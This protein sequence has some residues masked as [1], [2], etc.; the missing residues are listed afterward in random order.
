MFLN[1]RSHKLEIDCIF[2]LEKKNS[3]HIY[4]HLQIENKHK[5]DLLYRQF[6]I[7]CQ[8]FH[9]LS[10]MYHKKVITV[11]HSWLDKKLK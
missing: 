7:N 2:P 4:F 8:T 10:Y 3:R 1:T 9:A 5:T 11:A 6:I